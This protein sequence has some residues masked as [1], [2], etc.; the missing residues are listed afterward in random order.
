MQLQ[1]IIIRL[2]G[3]VTVV[4]EPEFFPHLI[5]KPGFACYGLI[6]PI[7]MDLNKSGMMTAKSVN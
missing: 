5:E 7:L 2:S 1:A 6:Y 4:F 3:A